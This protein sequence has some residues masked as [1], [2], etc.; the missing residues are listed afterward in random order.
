MPLS[1]LFVAFGLPGAGKTYVARCFAEFGFYVHDADDDLPDAMRAAI[2]A[3][4]PVTDA[5]RDEFFARIIAHVGELWAQYPRLVVA[6]TFIKEK[7]RHRFLERF[8][9]A[10][11]ILVEADDAVR[12]RRLIERLH[13]PLE[14]E[15]ARRMATFFDAPRIPHLL[16]QNNHDGSKHIREQIGVILGEL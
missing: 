13:Q 7:Y 10:Q 1:Q 12:E 5:M 2:N 6:Q 9:A 15:Y 8:P 11:F 3:S 14:P 16:L 4:L